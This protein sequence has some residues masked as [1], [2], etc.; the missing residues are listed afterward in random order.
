MNELNY[1]YAILIYVKFGI[2]F[3]KLSVQ[4]LSCHFMKFEVNVIMF[5]RHFCYYFGPGLESGQRSKHLCL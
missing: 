1:I 4:K 5:V 3:R 2:T